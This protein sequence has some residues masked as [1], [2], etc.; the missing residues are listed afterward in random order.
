MGMER[1]WH[2]IVIRF[3]STLKTFRRK[4]ADRY[5]RGRYSSSTWA[6][7]GTGTKAMADQLCQRQ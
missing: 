5:G 6:W 7:C 4:T 3:G 1:I 2:A